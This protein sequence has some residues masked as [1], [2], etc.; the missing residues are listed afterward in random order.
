MMVDNQILTY[1]LV[2]LSREVQKLRAES[3]LATDQLKKCDKERIE[4]KKALEAKDAA[5]EKV[6]K[7]KDELW[8]IVNTDKYRNIK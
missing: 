7:D 6:R 8:A 4:L 1:E 2:T 3:R 5:L